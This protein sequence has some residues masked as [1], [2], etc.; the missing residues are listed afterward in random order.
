MSQAFG[1]NIVLKQQ[2]I[3]EISLEI[4]DKISIESHVTMN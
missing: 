2:K 1:S 4:R 3:R